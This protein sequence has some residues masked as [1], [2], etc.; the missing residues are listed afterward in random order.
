MESVTIPES[1]K[2]DNWVYYV[3]CILCDLLVSKIYNLSGQ[4]EK[5]DG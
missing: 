1:Y 4:V 3:I 5:K 2:R